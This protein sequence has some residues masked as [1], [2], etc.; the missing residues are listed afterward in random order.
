MNIIFMRISE[1]LLSHLFNLIKVTILATLP[2]IR[3]RQ[4]ECHVLILPGFAEI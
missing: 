3:R 4:F 2:K 1:N